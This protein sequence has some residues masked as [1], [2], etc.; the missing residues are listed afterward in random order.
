MPHIRH[1]TLDDVPLITRQRHQM[2]ADNHFGTA[3]S[4]AAMDP[5]FSLWLKWHI[6]R[7]TYI[8]LL[9][10]AA[11]DSEVLA[12]AGIWFMDWPPHYLHA[13]PLRAYLLNFYTAP[14]ARG[15][16]YAKLLLDEAVKLSHARG[17]TVITLHA[18]PMGRPNYEAYGFLPSNEMM[19]K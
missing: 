12:A 1:A 19:L 16:G 4:L 14:E 5:A 15:R 17:A 11:Q 10:S 18:S 13:E 7:G 8:G 9:L 3:D 6:E 2:F